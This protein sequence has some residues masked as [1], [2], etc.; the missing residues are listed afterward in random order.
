MKITIGKFDPADKMVPVTFTDTGFD[1]RR[2]VAA[3]LTPA[4]DYDRAATRI[5]VDEV[6]HGVER[7]RAAGAFAVRTDD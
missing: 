7:K 3:V 1:H 5:R 6:A 4:G 2:R